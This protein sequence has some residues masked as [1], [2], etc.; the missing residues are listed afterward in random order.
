MDLFDDFFDFDGDGH[1]S[2]VEMAVG[3]DL[4]FGNDDNDATDENDG[5][6]VE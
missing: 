4:L 1:L 2:C 6:D 5:W 3:Y